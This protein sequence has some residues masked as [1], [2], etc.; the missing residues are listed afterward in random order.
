MPEFPKEEPEIGD[1]DRIVASLNA[2]GAEFMIVGGYAVI[3]HGFVRNTKDLDI[4]VRPTAENAQRTV[5]ALEKAGFGCPELKADLFT[6]GKGITYGEP[7]VRI[8]IISKI[9]SITFE[10]A[11][12]RREKSRFGPAAVNF[13][14]LDDL[15]CNKRAVGRTQDMLD[16]QRLEELRQE[17]ER[18]K[19]SDKGYGLD[20]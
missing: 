7:P 9:P 5:T 20:L 12:A 6:T 15:L 16:V 3:F 10:E 19:E 11:W 17:K 18:A 8:D 4:L 2:N 14:S 13:I 1:F